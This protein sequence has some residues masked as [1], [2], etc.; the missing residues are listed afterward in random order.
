MAWWRVW[1]DDVRE[2]WRSTSGAR[3]YVAFGLA[4]AMFAVAVLAFVV[5]VFAVLSLLAFAVGWP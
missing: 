5:A 4:S 2:I 3:R 1:V